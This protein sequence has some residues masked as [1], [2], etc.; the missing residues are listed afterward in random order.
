MKLNENYN[1]LQDSYLFAK[2]RKK[3]KEYKEKNE[4]ANVISLGVGD[5]T[6]PI[7]ECITDEMA[8][9]CKEQ[10]IKSKF[11][12]Y[13]NEQ[14]YEFL[15]EKIKKYYESKNVDI[16]VN[17]IFVSDGAKSDIANILDIFSKEC[18]V[19]IPAP[20]YPVYVDTN[21][22][23]GRN[24]TYIN[25]TYENNFLPLPDYNIKADIIYIC[26][27]N[28]PTGAVYNKE[29]LSEWIDYAIKQKAVILFDSAYEIFISDKSLPTS[30]YEIEG[31]K[32]C[33]IEIS[34][35]SKTAGFTGIRCGYTIVPLEIENAVINKMWLRRQTTKF[36]GVS[37]VVQRGAAKVFTNEGLEAVKVNIDYYMENATIIRETME[38]LNVWHT[39]GTNSP[40][41]WF[42]CPFKMKSWEFF[43][44]LLD[45]ANVV[46]TP[47]IGFGE[48]SDEYFR[49][50]SFASKEDVIEAMERFSSLITT[51]NK[52]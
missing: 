34:S 28:N 20:V 25:G 15:R 4:H 2:V 50:T 32:K 45:K 31:S 14:G 30:V 47:G 5:V 42:K 27:P 48:N 9:A 40:Y 18:N 12:G 37:Y 8:L 51:H 35:L 11:K 16:D 19:V 38:R 33:V 22:M 13:G 29:Q 10:S 24:I 23:D 44:L 1:N 21:I 52:I 17:E 43:D 46:G 36:N 3:V 6:L 41:V 26:S 7:P 39:G 49:F